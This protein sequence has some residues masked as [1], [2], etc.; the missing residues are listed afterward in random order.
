MKK[1]VLGL[2]LISSLSAFCQKLGSGITDIDG[3]N[4]NSVIIG[5]QEWT[6][7]NLNVSKYS[8]GTIIPQ[9][10]DPTAWFSLTT[11]AWCYN[12][13]NI[14][15]SL[16]YGK[17]YN[18]YAVAGIHDND[19]NTPNKSIA[20]EGW[21]VPS[22]EDWTILT[23]FLG[24]EFAAGAKMKELNIGLWSPSYVNTS[25][26][27]GFSALT[28]GFR[29]NTGDFNN[30]NSNCF[31]WSSTEYN[32]PNGN[33]YASL[34]RYLVISSPSIITD[35][36]SKLCG[37]SVR[38]LNNT[39]LNNQSFNKTNSF[40]IYPNP[41]KASVTIDCGNPSNIANQPYTINDALGK[42]ILKGKLNEGDTTINVEHLSKGIYY[43]KVANNKASKFIK[44]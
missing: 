27:S 5:T 28:S 16:N 14:E 36:N 15:N 39:L 37:F 17:L 4:Y 24:G 34:M 44:E 11:G 13:N 23:S 30:N 8:D 32:N 22:D 33:D 6:K 31:M 3:N 9:V 40:N 38:L 19:P 43:I 1:I 41:A 12:S 10:T 35:Y 2:I 18:W 7:E 25:N 42:I 21:H 20:P 29:Q 26:N